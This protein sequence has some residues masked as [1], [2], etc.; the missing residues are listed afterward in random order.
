MLFQDPSAAPSVPVK[1]VCAERF[2]ALAWKLAA[3][4]GMSPGAGI[5]GYRLKSGLCHVLVVVF[6]AGFP[7]PSQVNTHAY[8]TDRKI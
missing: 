7:H 4:S 8:L 1:G 5:G 2:L 3:V 6:G